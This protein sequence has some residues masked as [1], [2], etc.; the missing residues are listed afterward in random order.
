MFRNIGDASNDVVIASKM[1][2]YFD[3]KTA[4]N[5]LS[6][7]IVYETNRRFLNYTTMFNVVNI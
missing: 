3:N 5:E 4:V 7:I 6:G 1:K 2:T